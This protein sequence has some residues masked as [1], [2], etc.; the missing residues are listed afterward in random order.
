[1]GSNQLIFPHVLTL[2]GSGDSVQ[3]TDNPSLRVTTYTAELWVKYD[4]QPAHEYSGLF[5]KPG[6]G[7]Q[8]W[9]HRSG[10]VH[11]RYHTNKNTN[12][13]APDTPAGSIIWGRWHHLAITCDGKLA[14]TYIDGELRA[15][16]LVDGL[17]VSDATTLSVGVNPDDNRSVESRVHLTEVRLFSVA[18]TQEEIRATMRSRLTGREPNLVLYWPLS[19]LEPKDHS[20]NGNHGRLLGNPRGNFDASLPLTLAPPE[21]GVLALDGQRTRVAIGA[22]PELDEAVTIELWTR[23]DRLPERSVTLLEAVDQ[24]GTPLLSIRLPA[25]TELTWTAGVDGGDRLSKPLDVWDYAIGW[26]HWAFC[27]HAGS[28]RMAVYRNGVLWAEAPTGNGKRLNGRIDRLTIGATA[29]PA[30]GYFWAGEVAQLRIWSKARTTEQIQAHMLTWLRGD[31]DGLIGYWPL[32]DDHEQRESADREQRVREYA[33]RGRDGRVEQARWIRSTPPLPVHEFARAD[34]AVW[35]FAGPGALAGLRQRDEQLELVDGERATI[36]AAVAR[37]LGQRIALPPS[38]TIAAEQVG[39]PSLLALLADAWQ[40][41]RTLVRGGSSAPWSEGEPCKRGLAEFLRWAATVA[42][43][44]RVALVLLGDVLW[45]SS[46]EH[47]DDERGWLTPTRPNYP[48]SVYIKIPPPKSSMHSNAVLGTSGVVVSY[49]IVDASR[50][51]AAKLIVGDLYVAYANGKELTLDSTVSPDEYRNKAG[52]QSSGSS[53]IDPKLGTSL[54][55]AGYAEQ[56]T[57]TRSLDDETEQALFESLRYEP[58]RQPKRPQRDQDTPEPVE[59]V[60]RRVAAIVD[61]LVEGLPSTRL[62]LLATDSCDVSVVDHLA[63]LAP[64]FEVII[65]AQIDAP[66]ADWP[67]ADLL[68]ELIEAPR[69][70]PEPLATK[71]VA[72]RERLG[73]QLSRTCH[74]V[75][76]REQI[77]VDAPQVRL[78]RRVLHAGHDAVAIRTAGLEGLSGHIQLLGKVLAQLVDSRDDAALVSLRRCFLQALARYDAFTQRCDLPEL[79]DLLLDPS[80]LPSTWRRQIEWPAEAIRRSFDE[81]RVII[82]QA[83]TQGRALECGRLHGLSLH[84]P[85]RF[86][87]TISSFVLDESAPGDWRRVL[88]VLHDTDPRNRRRDPRRIELERRLQQDMAAFQQP[89]RGRAVHDCADEPSDVLRRP[90]ALLHYLPGDH[91]EGQPFVERMA[92]LAKLVR[93]EQALASVHVAALLD[94]PSSP[95]APLVWSSTRGR[96]TPAQVEQLRGVPPLARKDLPITSEA[97]TPAQLALFKWPVERRALSLSRSG[98]LSVWP[99]DG[100]ATQVNG[101]A[102]SVAE[103]LEFGAS[104]ERA[105]AAEYPLS[106]QQGSEVVLTIAYKAP[107]GGARLLPGPRPRFACRWSSDIE[108]LDTINSGRPETLQSFVLEAHHAAPARHVA[109]VIAGRA[110]FGGGFSLCQDSSESSSM[111][112]SVI[113]ESLRAAQADTHEPLALL[114]L[115]DPN[116]MSLEVAHELADVAHVLLTPTLAGEACVDWIAFARTLESVLDPSF[117]AGIE[118]A[119]RDELGEPGNERF[120]TLRERWRHAVARGAAQAL[121]ERLRDPNGAPIWQAIDLRLIDRVSRRL[122]TFCRLA[123]RGLTDT[124]VWRALQST[125]ESTPE[126]YP[127]GSLLAAMRSALDAAP[128]QDQLPAR[129]SGM[130]ARVQQLLEID[131]DRPLEQV[132]ADALEFYNAVVHSSELARLGQ[133]TALAKHPDIGEPLAV[134]LRELGPIARF[135][136]LLGVYRSQLREQPEPSLLPQVSAPAPIKWQMLSFAH[137]KQRATVAGGALGP[138]AVVQTNAANVAHQHWCFEEVEIGWFRVLARHSGLALSVEAAGTQRGAKLVVA[139]YTADPSQHWALGFGATGRTLINRKSGLVLD[140]PGNNEQTQAHLW[141]AH[142]Q[143][144]QCSVLAPAAADFGPEPTAWYTLSFGHSGQ[145]LAVAGASTSDDAKLVQ[146]AG[147]LGHAHALWRFARV[148]GDAFALMARH[149]GKL[150]ELDGRSLVLRP[151]REG[152][153]GQQW[154]VIPCAG[155]WALC[156]RSSGYPL[157]VVNAAMLDGAA[158][159]LG[160]GKDGAPSWTA[161]QCFTIEPFVGQVQLLADEQAWLDRMVQAIRLAAKRARAEQRVWIAGVPQHARLLISTRHQATEDY[162]RL[163]FHDDVQLHLLLSAYRLLTQFDRDPHALWGLISVGLGHAPAPVVRHALRKLIG[164]QK[165]TMPPL[166][167]A[168]IGA[169]PLITMALEDDESHPDRYELRLTSSES[170]ALLLRQQSSVNPGAIE[171]ALDGLDFLLERRQVS[172]TAWHYLESLGASLGED[173]INHLHDRLEL[174]RQQLLAVSSN[175]DV[176]LALAIPRELM[177]YPWELMFVPT[178]ER[179]RSKQML[180]ERFAIG[181]QIWSDRGR[182]AELGDADG[183]IKILIIGDPRSELAPPLPGARA[184]ALAIAEL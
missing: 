182:R 39:E 14:R 160:S 48:K 93:G 92:K 37:A 157:T 9:I 56:K 141:D 150:L 73:S 127:L 158:V 67:L 159:E 47:L 78:A 171:H 34:W 136:E 104:I 45:A 120:S 40:G 149:S 110:N 16:G 3:I 90:W 82:A 10:F 138:A 172:Q 85:V 121:V 163:R 21:H 26:T 5:G 52:S 41:T 122:D 169:A 134:S 116:M 42:P 12:A 23:L 124:V 183:K 59:R 147:A 101:P 143:P 29:G 61:A 1:M 109:L 99:V 161:S 87:G 139:P 63:P 69:I 165:L 128:E 33:G 131:G 135:S 103:L 83:H 98:G 89:A 142:G 44:E 6:R 25:K 153:V 125:L 137:T 118:R 164:S 126:R 86:E 178:D 144:N 74:R 24:M 15:E 107:S 166:R 181:R 97:P 94:R 18:R 8:I 162:T 112:I 156:S 180:A 155:G 173:I 43:G 117:A 68:A 100:H 167:L 51:T 31:E 54:L 13:G 123:V 148:S 152:A 102:Q 133:I 184:E 95:E 50:G 88:A 111:S 60:R 154:R 7:H 4:A 132:D 145:R 174:E 75:H 65:G 105:S 19:E 28:G 91:P 168:S 72:R 62:H 2:D 32:D 106:G 17:L 84:V 22:Q 151:Y 176:H 30:P 79:L 76:E 71:V 77:M 177:R 119:A 179:M 108:Q 55:D 140:I 146:S 49:E 115:A 129:L 46:S 80:G 175:D 20:P 57:D 70:E 113:A 64:H 11:H 130:I 81:R 53:S 114:I 38:V 66:V 58:T 35:V 170:A 96:L 36:L 27:K